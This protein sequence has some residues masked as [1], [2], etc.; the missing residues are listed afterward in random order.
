M[1]HKVFKF[2]LVCSLFFS[3]QI[4]AGNNISEQRKNYDHKKPVKIMVEDD[5]PMTEKQFRSTHIIE[6]VSL[7]SEEQARNLI[8]T[9]MKQKS[10]D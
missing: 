4:F 5:D 10:K 7:K 2:F 8:S 6:K 9:V 3:T 1:I